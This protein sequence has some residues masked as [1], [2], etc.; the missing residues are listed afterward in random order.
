MEIYT[1][2]MEI[3]EKD[4]IILEKLKQNSSVTIGELSKLTGIP[5]TTIH[6][7]IKRMEKD[8]VIKNYTLEL[9]HVKL[10]NAITAYLMVHTN[11]ML[12][13]GIKVNQEDIAKEIKTIDN[14]ESVSLLAGGADILAKIRVKDVNELNQIVMKQIRKIDGVDKTHTMIV[15]SEY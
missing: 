14:I 12:A 6:N 11:S 9:D 15:L 1:D 13:S 4:L 2:K 10:G 8:K 5:I 7:R 3:N